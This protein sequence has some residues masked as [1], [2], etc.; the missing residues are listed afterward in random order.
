MQAN[1]GT[2]DR[3]L[4]IGG[5]LILIALAATGTVGLWG[6]IGV[7]PVLTGVFRFCPAYPLIG[8]NTCARKDL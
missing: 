3:S 7:V 8:M 1:V 2:L 5:G 6:W 4:R